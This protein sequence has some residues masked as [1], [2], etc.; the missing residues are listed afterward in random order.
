MPLAFGLDGIKGYLLPSLRIN[1]CDF[2]DS[3]YQKKY[4]KN[5]KDK[6]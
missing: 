5:L 6:A 3:K 1:N 4:S 2:L